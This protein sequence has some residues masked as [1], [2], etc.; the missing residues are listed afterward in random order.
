MAVEAHCLLP[1]IRGRG[2]AAD[3]AETKQ[4]YGDCTA[5]DLASAPYG[6]VA[7]PPLYYAPPT[8]TATDSGATFFADAAAPPRKRARGEDEPF[9]GMP[10]HADKRR[11]V[12]VHPAVL[13]HHVQRM[14]AEVQQWRLHAAHV[15]NAAVAERVRAKDEEIDQARWQNFLLQEQLTA[16]HAEARAWRDAA[17]NG[18]AA[19]AALRADLDHALRALA[20]AE[21]NAHADAK[22][23]ASC[24]SGGGNDDV[25]DTATGSLTGGGAG[26]VCR[27]CGERGAAVVVLP[28]RHLSACAPCAAAATAC[29]ACGCAKAGTVAVNLYS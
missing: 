29:P 12:G 17:A 16:A 14:S 19:A 1:V 23:A 10:A 8:A 11:V 25:G 27:G 18:E 24:C 22:D 4:R 6:D 3:A 20:E 7:G 28:C 21:A 26:G 13:L 15:A 9:V 5:V 2:V